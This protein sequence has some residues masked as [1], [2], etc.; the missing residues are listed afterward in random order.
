MKFSPQPELLSSDPD[1]IKTNLLSRITPR[2]F[3][4]LLL[5]FSLVLIFTYHHQV[6][7]YIPWDFQQSF[8]RAGGG[9]Y[10]NFFYGY[11]VMPL[12]W[13]L[14]KIPM[15]ISFGIW[16]A[17]NL[18]G[19]FFASRVFGGKSWLALISYQMIYVVFYGQITGLMLGG[20]ALAWWGFASRKVHL[21]GLGLLLAAVKPQF[22]LPLALILWVLAEITWKER[23]LTL[24]VPFL[25]IVL[26]FALYPNWVQNILI[27]IQ[28]GKVDFTGDISLWR[29]LGPWSLLFFLPPVLMKNPRS[30]RILLLIATV[31][32]A[33]PYLQQTEL[34]ALFVFPFGWLSLIGNLGFL[35][36]L[37]EWEVLSWLFLLPLFIYLVMIFQNL[38]QI[39]RK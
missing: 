18:L 35:F 25:G 24:V 28:N 22:G 13:L 1:Q 5:L 6:G 2:E 30:Q 39:S 3:F 32:F 9:D 14:E 8:L 36:P 10:S 11:W 29:Y 34:L 17:L 23:L 7:F 12:F 26:T 15:W 4:S 27:A 31:C 33:S 38:Y 20:L 16:S 19:V 37:F 21:A